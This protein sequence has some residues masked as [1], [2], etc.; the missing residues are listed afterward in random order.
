MNAA[1]EASSI[2]KSSWERMLPWL[3]ARSAAIR[4]LGRTRLCEPK[5]ELLK[6]ACLFA[7]VSLE[8]S[9]IRPDNVDKP[10]SVRQENSARDIA[11]SGTVAVPPAAGELISTLD[12]KTLKHRA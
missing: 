7:G 9:T 5:F 3:R 12:T 10:P 4:L 11:L 1:R 6:S 2:A 8:G